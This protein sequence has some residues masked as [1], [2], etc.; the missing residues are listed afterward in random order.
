RPIDRRHDDAAAKFDPDLPGTLVFHLSC[1][2]HRAGQKL[3]ILVPEDQSKAPQPKRCCM[4]LDPELGGAEEP[5]CYFPLPFFVCSRIL[6][7]R[8]LRSGVSSAPKSSS[9]KTCRISISDS[10]SCGL[11]Q[12]LTHSTASSIDLSCHSQ[13][14]AISSLVS[15][16]GPSMTVRFSPE[17]RTRLPFEV[18]CS[19]S[20]ASSTPALTSS[21]LNF[22]I[23]ASSFCFGITPASDFSLALTMTKN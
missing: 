19:P 17:N 23:S 9:S 11:G 10:P 4:T 7:S 6:S 12:R 5:P 14:P 1:D 20:A 3:G 16:K 15:V 18:G 21:S 2:L 13:K 22:P 8:S